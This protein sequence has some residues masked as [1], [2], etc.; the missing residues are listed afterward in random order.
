MKTVARNSLRCAALLTAI[1]FA[2]AALLAQMD[3]TSSS[4]SSAASSDTS[5]PA[6]GL[7]HSD[8]TFFK[9]AAEGGMKEVAVSQAVMDHLTNSSVKEF[10]QMMIT[11]HTAANAD[12]AMLAGNKGVT[13]PGPDD[14]VAEKWSKKDNGADKDYIDEMVGDHKEVVK[15]F[16]KASQSTDADI[17]A[18]AQKM[19]PTLQHHLAVAQDL[20]KTL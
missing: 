12:L 16:E 13:L 10:A 20:Q 2:P 14:K 8:R 15:L 9:K 18:F 3:A 17:A 19:L 4:T 11:D 1:S 6:S 5:A 7:K